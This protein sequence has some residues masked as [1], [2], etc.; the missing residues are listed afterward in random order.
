MQLLTLSL[1][2]EKHNRDDMFAQST[3]LSKRQREQK[4]V[5]ALGKE[6]YKSVTVLL[7]QAKGPSSPLC[8]DVNLNVF[9]KLTSLEWRKITPSPCCLL[10]TYF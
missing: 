10:A 9:G 6:M 7:V 4:Q 2:L 8:N 5:T 1:I 3:S